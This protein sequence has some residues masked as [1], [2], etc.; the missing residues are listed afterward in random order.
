MLP[1]TLPILLAAAGA[2]APD[3]AQPAL[4]RLAAPFLV[5][6]GGLPI[7]AVTGHAAPFLIDL[8]DD[9]RLDLVVGEFGESGGRARIYLNQ[10]SAQKPRFEGFSWLQAGGADATVPSS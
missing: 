2:Q 8:D 6:A 9:G 10:G 7:A 3:A 4:P 1:C 5:E